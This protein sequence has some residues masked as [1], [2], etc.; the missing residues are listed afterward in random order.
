MYCRFGNKAM[1]RHLV[2]VFLNIKTIL[3]FYVGESEEIIY[4]N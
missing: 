4:V 1:D 2:G 3:D